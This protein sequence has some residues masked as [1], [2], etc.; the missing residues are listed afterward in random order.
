MSKVKGVEL[1]ASAQGNANKTERNVVSGHG[2]EHVCTYCVHQATKGRLGP[3]HPGL[4][5]ISSRE[6]LNGSSTCRESIYRCDGCGTFIL[7]LTTSGNRTLDDHVA[8]CGVSAQR[9]ANDEL[10]R[11]SY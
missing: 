6:I 11:Q 8:L 4:R 2:S 7:R 1:R 9:I 3:P 5:K 10:R